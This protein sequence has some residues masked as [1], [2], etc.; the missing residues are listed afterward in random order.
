MYIQR[1][2]KITFEEIIW[3]TKNLKKSKLTIEKYKITNINKHNFGKL[4]NKNCKGKLM[5]YYY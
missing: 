2:I 4:A 3:E 1:C 5:I